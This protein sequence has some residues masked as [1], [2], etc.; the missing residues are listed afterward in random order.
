MRIPAKNITPGMKLE[1]PVM[2][3]SGLMM[4]GADIELTEALVKKIR[5][6]DI[7]A[8]Y[9]HGK[10]TA[11]PPLDEV[12]ARFEG[13]FRKVESAPHM[14]VLKRLLREHIEGLYEAHGS[15]NPEE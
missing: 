8:V 14:D 12:L 15:E 10:P 1:R 4:I 3:K 9:V 11:L 7:Q 13:R 6:M 2:N 5:K